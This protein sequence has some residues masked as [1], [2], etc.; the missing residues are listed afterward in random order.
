ML[1]VLRKGKG[2]LTTHV[3]AARGAARGRGTVVAARGAAHVVAARR[4]LLVCARCPTCHFIFIREILIYPKWE[5]I[6]A[7]SWACWELFLSAEGKWPCAPSTAKYACEH[8]DR[9]I[10]FTDS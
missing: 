6:T 7:R 1:R 5:R 2:R 9:V 8:L 10:H 4:A 3:V